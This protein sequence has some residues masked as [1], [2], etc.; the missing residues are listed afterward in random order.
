V[1]PAL[2]TGTV[3]GKT[4]TFTVTLT[5]TGEKLGPFVLTFGV[6]SRLFK[7]A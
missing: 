3:T 1:H 5:D 7:C 2:Y 6:A 4:M